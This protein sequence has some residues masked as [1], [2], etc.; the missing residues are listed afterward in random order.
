MLWLNQTDVLSTGIGSMAIAQP[1]IEAAFHLLG[2]DQVKMAPEVPLRCRKVSTDEAFYS[3]P[4]YVGGECQVAGIKWTTHHPENKEK[5]LPHIFTL[6]ALSDP[7][8]GLPLAIM[9]AS[10]IGAMRTGA[11]TATAL[12]YLA[13]PSAETLFCCGAGVQARQQILGAMH[14]LPCLQKI[15]IWGRTQ[16]KAEKLA[17]ELRPLAGAIALEVVSDTA[18]VKAS[19]IV[20]SVTSASEPYLQEEDFKDGVLYCHVGFN[21]IEPS[22][23]NSFDQVVYDDFT[24]GVANSGQSIFR[25]VRAGT[26]DLTKNAGLL[27]EVVTGKKQIRQE[28][29]KKLMF[30]AFGLVV[31]DIVL[32]YYAYRYGKEHG[33]GNELTLWDCPVWR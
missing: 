19:D 13:A 33:I 2:T 6:L 32:G 9:E 12:K 21:E 3:L 5:G 20:I 16:T 17:A 7:N 29:G 23:I 25:M 18:L 30:D 4:A 8:T 24:M 11:V 28:K 15:R 1:Q 22:A 31:F 14:S 10:V 27:G 26:F